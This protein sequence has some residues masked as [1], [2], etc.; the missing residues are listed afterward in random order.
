MSFDSTAVTVDFGLVALG[1]LLNL[2]E[3]MVAK[4]EYRSVEEMYHI[5]K[6]KKG[7]EKNIFKW[8]FHDKRLWNTIVMSTNHA[9]ALRF[10]QEKILGMINRST[11]VLQ[12]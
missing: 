1:F 10:L 11:N 12:I 7:T 6:F 2:F 4:W 9:V 5:D 3:T 8:I